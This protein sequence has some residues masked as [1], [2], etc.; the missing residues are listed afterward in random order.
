MEDTDE[1]VRVSVTD[2]PMVMAA[3][4]RLALVGAWQRILDA[5]PLTEPM[6][7]VDADLLV[8]AG[9]LRYDEGRY[10]L[11]IEQPWFRNPVAIANWAPAYLRRAL[12]HALG[13]STGWTAA[14]KD[15]VLAQGRA[16]AAA[17]EF[18]AGTVLPSLPVIAARFDAGTAVFLDVGVGVAAISLR[19]AN[20]FVGVRAVGLDVLPEVLELAGAE[21]KDQSLG[22]RVEVRH[23]SV[24]D[25][26]DE[27][28]YDLAWLP[29]MFIPRDAFEQGLRRV[30]RAL[31]PGGALVLP[32]AAPDADT[33]PIDQA[34]LTHEAHV[35]GGGPLPAEEAEALLAQAGYGA[36]HR[37]L[38]GDGLVLCAEKD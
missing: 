13:G 22:D 38:Y 20:R 28:A 32:L 25:L 11:A 9:I 3:A 17:A 19:L 2:H 4:S 29:H 31:R 33:P 16:S 1:S 34:L 23:M 8:A 24:A 27:D 10:A 30:Q 26:A 15:I 18:I 21:I 14:D 37:H 6:D 35:L 12:R 36:I 7:T 5:E